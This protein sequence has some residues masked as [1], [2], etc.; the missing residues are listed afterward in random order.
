[1][2]AKIS[3]TDAQWLLNV[4]APIRGG[5]V[6]NSTFGMFLKAYNMMKGADRKVNC[7]SCEGRT[8]A[9]V[10]NSIFEQYQQ[11]I[12]TIASKTTRKR[13]S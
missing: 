10:A 1:M 9:A 2:L 11:E 4:W 3:K 6:D 13:K 12:E 5:R 8:I 7:F